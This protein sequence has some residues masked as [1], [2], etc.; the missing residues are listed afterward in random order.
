M[1]SVILKE[2]WEVQHESNYTL[3]QRVKQPTVDIL[4]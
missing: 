3:M 2:K 4:K 1:R